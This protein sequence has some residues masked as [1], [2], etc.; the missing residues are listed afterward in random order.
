MRE[1][2]LYVD[3]LSSSWDMLYMD[4]LKAG[5]FVFGEGKE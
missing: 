2:L 3:E 4:R 1:F 5:E